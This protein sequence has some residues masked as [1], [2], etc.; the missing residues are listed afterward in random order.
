M[1]FDLYCYRYTSRHTRKVK[2]SSRDQ[3]TQLAHKYGCELTLTRNAKGYI[4]GFHF[5]APSSSVEIRGARDW[6]PDADRFER[7][8]WFLSDFFIV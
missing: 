4:D 1:V 5:S 3:L 2:V 6:K 8:S 7:F